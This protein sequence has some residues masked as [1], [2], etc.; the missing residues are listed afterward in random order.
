MTIGDT[1]RRAPGRHWLGLFLSW[2]VCYSAVLW[3]L[4][5]CYRVK[6]LD[7]HKVPRT[8]AWIF[9]CNHQS[10]LDPMIMGVL[11]Q[12]RAPASMAR[13]SLFDFKPFG[14][15]LRFLGSVP[16]ERGKG[17]KAAIRTLLEELQAGRCIMLFP[18]GT[19]TKDGAIGMFH[20]GVLTLVRRSGAGVVPVAV[21]GAYD[22][23]PRERRLPRLRGRLRTRALDPMTAEE[24]TSV[25]PAEAV[26]ELKRRIETA[27]LEL[28]AE[29]REQTRGWW[30]PP[31]LGDQPYWERE[32]EA[33][34]AESDEPAPAPDEA[35]ASS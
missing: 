29:L 21:D 14:K 25:P 15:L 35:S 34:R 28:R 32:A 3:F 9:A 4:T 22:I 6:R 1:Q 10:H 7:R 5:I 17:D 24:L 30:P 18:E 8:G 27:R 23:W 31:G 12:D 33:A 26:E 19:R 20:A 11:V 16:V 13:K 2:N